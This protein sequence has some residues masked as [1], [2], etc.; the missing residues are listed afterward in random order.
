METRE[1][2]DKVSEFES[3]C[4]SV[5]SDLSTWRPLCSA[6]SPNESRLNCVDDSRHGCPYPCILSLSCTI[7]FLCLCNIIRLHILGEEV[8]G[9]KS[10][11]RLSGPPTRLPRLGHTTLHVIGLSSINCHHFPVFA[12]TTRAC[13]LSDA[14]AL[15]PCSSSPHTRSSSL[16]TTTCSR[17]SP[18]WRQSTR[19]CSTTPAASHTHI[20]TS[21]YYTSRV[22]RHTS[23]TKT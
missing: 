21:Q 5:C 10:R 12:L 11:S 16:R 6:T 19:R 3:L 7:C 14:N 2:A 13:A 4:T 20:C 8:R 17:R 18:R 23:R 9:S 22:S 15:A 1:L